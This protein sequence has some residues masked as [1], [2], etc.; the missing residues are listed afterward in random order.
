[1]QRRRVHQ[2]G[3]ARHLLDADPL[4][5]RRIEAA[6]DLLDEG[7]RLLDET[8]RT[9]VRGERLLLVVQTT[10]AI[11][12][13][14][15]VIALCEIG[16]GVPASMLNRALLEEVLEVSWVAA[17]PDLAPARADEHDRLIQLAERALEEQLGEPTTSLSAEERKELSRLRAKYDGFQASWTLASVPERLDLVKARWG[18]NTGRAIDMLYERVQ[19]QN[20]V[21]L[22]ASPTAYGYAMTHG[23]R[24]INR[25]GP[26]PRWREA[27]SH[28]AVGFYLIVRVLADAF[29]IDWQVVEQRFDVLRCLLSDI[30][31]ERVA[32]LPADA[33]CPCGSGRVLSRC[34]QA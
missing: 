15:S 32:G 16:R 2:V 28:G 20:N 13:F 34:H 5:S 33:P 25:A 9:S 4:Y 1:V 14:E 11:H 10:R 29:H 18:P 12:I 6:K 17:N 31:P 24:N 30:E 8:G 19:R 23:R 27:L 22:H 21:L 26:D 7:A 3:F